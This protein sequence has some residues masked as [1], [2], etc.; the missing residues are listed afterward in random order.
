MLGQVLRLDLVVRGEPERARRGA[1]GHVRHRGVVLDGDHA[2]VE[3]HVVVGAEAQ[4]VA[5]FV[6]A[7]AMLRRAVRVEE[8]SALSDLLADLAADR[9]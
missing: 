1:R 6:G 3:Q 4:E 2:S 8:E 5:G 9:R 7:A